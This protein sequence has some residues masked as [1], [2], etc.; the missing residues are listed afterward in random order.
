MFLNAG[1]IKK[2]SAFLQLKPGVLSFIYSGTPLTDH[3]VL[4]LLVVGGARR[5]MR[6]IRCIE[7]L[8]GCSFSA[9]F[10][11]MGEMVLNGQSC[12]GFDRNCAAANQ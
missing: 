7:C 4:M 8:A 9:Q 5:V 11:T 2:N 12:P 1:K 3:F 10:A 6:D